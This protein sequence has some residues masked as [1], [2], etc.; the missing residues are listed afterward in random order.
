MVAFLNG[1]RRLYDFAD[2]NPMVEMRPV[3]YTNDTRVILRLDNMIAINS[4]LE[5]DL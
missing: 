3:D 1:T 2:D 4:A 5:I